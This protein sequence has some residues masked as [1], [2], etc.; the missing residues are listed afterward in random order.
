MI[1]D[2]GD[3]LQDGTGESSQ[4]TD[5]DRDLLVLELITTFFV[6]LSFQ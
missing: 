4:L 5:S 6:R 2:D 3:G 1:L